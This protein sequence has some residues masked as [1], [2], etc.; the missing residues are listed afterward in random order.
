LLFIGKCHSIENMERK[1]KLWIGGGVGLVVIVGAFFALR[2]G[3]VGAKVRAM[4]ASEISGQMRNDFAVLIDAR[5]YSVVAKGSP[6]GA[7]VVL[8]SDVA[9]RIGSIPSQKTLVF[10]CGDPAEDLAREWAGRGRQTAY[11]Q[12]FEEWKSAGLPVVRQ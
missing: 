2:G 4:S 8:V 12:S 5:P 11:L 7:F 3:G 9:S 1:K 6:Q 10:C